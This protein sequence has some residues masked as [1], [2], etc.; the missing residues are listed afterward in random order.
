MIRLLSSSLVSFCLLTGCNKKPVRHVAESPSLVVTP[1]GGVSISGDS[2]VAPKVDTAKTDSVLPIPE[3]STFVFNEKLATVTLTVSKAT[4]L[5]LNR[6]ETKV[7]GPKSFTPDKAPT[8][9]EEKAA[10]S[11]FWTMLGLRAG[12]AIGAA[13]G[14]FGLVRSWDMVM[15]GGIA[16]SGACLFGLFV[17]KHPVLLAVIGLGVAACVIGPIIWHTKLKNK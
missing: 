15:Y 10:E 8:I 1:T 17:Q 14:I 5:A 2:Q 13:L 12:I 6:T 3:G 16:I 7:E 11:D 4:S 9:A